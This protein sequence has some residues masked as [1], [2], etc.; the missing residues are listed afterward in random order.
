M[1]LLNPLSEFESLHRR[2]RSVF[3]TREEYNLNPNICLNCGKPILC[4]AGQ[5]LSNVRKKKFCNQSC[6][7]TYN[8][9]NKLKKAYYCQKCG[10]LLGYGYEEFHRRKYC[11]KCN[12]NNIDWTKRTYGEVKQ[13]RQY[14]VNSRIRE[15]ARNKFIKEHPNAICAICGYS[16]H[17]EVHHIKGIS[18]FPDEALISEINNDNNLIA[19]CP[20]CHWEV[21]NG[22][23]NL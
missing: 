17:I 14:Q 7:A 3:M 12:P 16:K 2:Q 21:E 20:N 22:W 11:E 4:M 8:N 1:G 13:L 5:Q 19:L 15:L 18:T 10:S 6:S 9:K 23:L